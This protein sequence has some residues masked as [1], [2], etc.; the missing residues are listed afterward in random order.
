MTQKIL[1]LLQ[2]KMEQEKEVS[3]S[4]MSWEIASN[5]IHNVC[6]FLIED[7][8]WNQKW[9]DETF[10]FEP[11]QWLG[12]SE[13]EVNSVNAVNRKIFFDFLKSNFSHL[14]IL[15]YFNQDL[16]KQLMKCEL[17]GE[18][19]YQVVQQFQVK[20]IMMEENPSNG[21]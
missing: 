19:L 9:D 20:W 13:S 5:I 10:S 7:G 1:K 6:Q 3:L 15:K 14:N 12:D 4:T 17:I 2:L 11:F 8:K 16:S 18:N 21:Y